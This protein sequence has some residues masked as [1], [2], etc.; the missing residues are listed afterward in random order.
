VN[1]VYKPFRKSDQRNF[2]SSRAS[3]PKI[4]IVTEKTTE[5]DSETDYHAVHP[6]FG[7]YFFK[8]FNFGATVGPKIE[9]DVRV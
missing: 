9:A 5:T 1:G 4:A 6:V 2:K 3:K 8:I 7:R